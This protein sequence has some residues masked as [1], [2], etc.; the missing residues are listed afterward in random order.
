MQSLQLLPTEGHAGH[1]CNTLIIKWCLLW[2][3]SDPGHYKAA[4]WAMSISNFERHL[5]RRTSFPFKRGQTLWS[6]SK[7]PI[8]ISRI[9][10]RKI[11]LENAKRCEKC[12]VHHHHL[13]ILLGK[14]Y[15][16]KS[17]FYLKLSGQIVIDIDAANMTI[18]WQ[19]DTLCQVQKGHASWSAVNA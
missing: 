13:C 12:K 15:A 9:D 2:L 3:Q 7:K 6:L 1:F 16:Q 19:I 5:T 11:Q 10:V 8:P 18:K 4:P 14:F 17:I